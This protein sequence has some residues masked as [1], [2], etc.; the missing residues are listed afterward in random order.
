MNEE[1][2]NE[3]MRATTIWLVCHAADAAL[4][5]GTFPRAPEVGDN[6]AAHALDGRAREAVEAWRARW[7]ARLVGA[8]GEP[9]RALTSPAAIARASAHAAGFAAERTDALADAAYGAWQGRRLTDVARE[10]PEAL[11][12]W[13]R[14]PAFRPPGGGASFDDVR[15]R[16]AAWLDA[17]PAAEQTI[18]TFTHAPVIRAAV[19]HA[20]DAP[21]SSFR[22]VE[23]APLAVTALRRSPQ[24]WVWVAS[25]P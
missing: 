24:G 7:Q 19:L 3:P 4:R 9:P 8:D 18:V 16:V 13:T 23:I 22:R 6:D 17:L 11:A 15:S 21:S 14:D 2:E 1:R 20:L 5:S 25:L 10:A 12:A